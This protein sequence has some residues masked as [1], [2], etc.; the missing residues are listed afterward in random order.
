[1]TIGQLQGLVQYLIPV[2]YFAVILLATW[3]VARLA[4]IVTG[5]LLRQSVP[6][7]VTQAKR[8]V[9]LIVW[10]I[11]IVLAIEQLG[12]R[13]DIL[14][15]MVGLVGV[16][17]IIALRVPL[18]NIGAK[19]FTDVYVPFKVGD[20]ITVLNHSGKVV[21]VN[22]ITT[23]LLTDDDRLV[24]VPNSAMISEVVMNS[25]PQAWKELT[26]PIVIGSSIDLAAFESNVLKNF[27]KLRLHLDKRFPPVL[28]IKS[29]TPQSTELTLTIMILRPEQRDTIVTEVNKR[30]SE[31][32]KT[33]QQQ[34]K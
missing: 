4:S 22:S 31:V 14:L 30:I 33:M 29:R 1:M 27:N 5:S 2:V 12:I 9:W 21:E 16:G 32:I 19:Y 23:I 25:T 26:I 13:S 28:T 34:K 18:E 24:S 11:G 15:V 20:S 10:L 6:L 7:L 8:V 3:V 17:A